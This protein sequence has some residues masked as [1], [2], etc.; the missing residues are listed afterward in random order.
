MVVL[1]GCRYSILTWSGLKYRLPSTIAP[2]VP[3]ARVTPCQVADG[4]ADTLV[5]DTP[6]LLKA[7]L[8]D[9][10]PLVCA[11]WTLLASAC[12]CCHQLITVFDCTL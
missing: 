10:Q 7:A 5:E 12:I 1:E 11:G 3:S 2:A 9:L 6:A 8:I 4:M